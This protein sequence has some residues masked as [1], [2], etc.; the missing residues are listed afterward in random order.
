ME[1]EEGF[2]LQHQDG[3]PLLLYTLIG[4][5]SEFQIPQ[6]NCTLTTAS[7]KHVF[8]P[9]SIL[10]PPKLSSVFRVQGR[11]GSHCVAGEVCLLSSER[12]LFFDLGEK[13]WR[14][15]SSIIESSGLPQINRG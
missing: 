5:G 1:G 4:V 14:R 15:R 11:K 13:K 8:T 7:R 9:P 6:P 2:S 3:N 12:V 10:L